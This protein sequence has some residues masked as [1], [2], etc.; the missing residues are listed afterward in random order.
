[1]TTFSK[2][3]L[4]ILIFMA[5]CVLDHQL[6]ILLAKF[7]LQIHPFFSFMRLIFCFLGVLMANFN[8]RGAKISSIDKY[9]RFEPIRPPLAKI[10]DI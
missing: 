1:M 9:R 3:H 4:P 6:S 5:K 10:E 2:S 7:L 8:K